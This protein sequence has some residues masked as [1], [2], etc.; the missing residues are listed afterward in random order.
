MTG[1]LDDTGKIPPIANRGVYPVVGG[2]PVPQFDWYGAT[3]CAPHTVLLDVIEQALL[4]AGEDTIRADGGKV[5]RYAA[6]T[7]ITDRKGRK[8]AAVKHGGAYPFPHFEAEGD[9]S[10]AVAE[11]V[12]AMDALHKPTR[13]DSAVD[14]TRPGLFDELHQV[15]RR[16]EEKYRL[17]LNYAGAAVDNDQRGTTIYLGSRKSQVFLRIYQKGLQLAEQQGLLPDEIPPEML[18]WVR[19]EIVFRP[20][21]QP[22]KAFAAHCSPDEVWGVSA[23]TRDFAMAS[24][25]IKAERVKMNQRRESDHERA[26]RHMALQYRSHLH[27]L[28]VECGGDY[29]EAMAVLVDLAGLEAQPQAA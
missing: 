19:A 18:N 8:L 2:V 17:Q 12:R 10:P 29:S 20:E 22:S 14:Q 6:I 11:A 25:S 15:A 1:N 24:L 27:R 21:K 28:L 5:R 26:L 9:A 4:D 13:I 16:L 23:W 3:V 7:F